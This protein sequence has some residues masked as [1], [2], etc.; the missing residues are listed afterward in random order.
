MDEQFIPMLPEQI[1]HT[2]A[3]YKQAYV[4]GLRREICHEI[5]CAYLREISLLE[6]GLQV[7]LLAEYR[8]QKKRK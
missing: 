1:R 8:Q 3:K 7:S 6:K 5:L 2:I 4:V